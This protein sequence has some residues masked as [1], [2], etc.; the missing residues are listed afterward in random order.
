MQ[1]A[2]NIGHWTNSVEQMF[3]VGI[4]L[5]TLFSPWRRIVTAGGRGLDA[6]MQ[7][8]FDNLVSRLVGFFVRL[9]VIIA[10]CVSLAGVFLI[11]LVM[12]I[13]WPFIPI[14][15]VYCLVR[16]ITG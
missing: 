6:K 14:G 7:A 3:S 10:A 11:G 8:M 9:M 4:L 16:S 15:I 5:R 1:A 2:R 13:V 12:V